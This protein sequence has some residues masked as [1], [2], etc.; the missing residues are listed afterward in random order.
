MKT[1]CIFVFLILTVNLFGQGPYGLDPTFGVNGVATTYA[2]A[3]VSCGAN[4]ITRLADGKIIAV[5]CAAG[6]H[7]ALVRYDS[8]GVVDTTF[9]NGGIVNSVISLGGDQANRV[10]VQPDGKLLVTGMIY[11]SVGVVRYL[12]N[13]TL[14]SLFGTNGLARTSLGPVWSQLSTSVALQTDG[15]IVIGGYLQNNS[16]DQVSALIR[17]TS[18]GMLDST[19]GINGVSFI[20][21]GPVSQIS[22]LK[23]QPNGKPMVPSIQ[24]LVRMDI[25]LLPR[26]QIKVKPME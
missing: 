4:G 21:F 5:G 11:S 2:G 16:N 3:W 13:G 22:D 15:K 18:G 19:F 10:I 23:I 1:I 6:G 17:F 24:H 9:G 12:A 7:F 8:T 14:D 26:V 25:L 20:Y